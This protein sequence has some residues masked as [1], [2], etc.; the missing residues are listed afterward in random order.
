MFHFLS[1]S[2]EIEV[3]NISQCSGHIKTCPHPDPG[4]PDPLHRNTEQFKNNRK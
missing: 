2:S 1:L 3:R 4:H